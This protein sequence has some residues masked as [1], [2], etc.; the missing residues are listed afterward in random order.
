[1]TAALNEARTVSMNDALPQSTTSDRPCVSPPLDS[2]G[3][4]PASSGVKK[5]VLPVVQALCQDLDAKVRAA[6]CLHLDAL[7]RAIG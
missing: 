3:D 6:M 4:V 1:M 5:E 2:D 7:T